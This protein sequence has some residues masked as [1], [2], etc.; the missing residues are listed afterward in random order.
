MA[1]GTF[2]SICTEWPGGDGG[3]DDADGDDEDDQEHENG[4]D[5]RGPGYRPSARTAVSISASSFGISASSS[6]IA[7]CAPPLSTPMFTL[8]TA[9]SSGI[10]GCGPPLECESLL[11]SMSAS[12]VYLFRTAMLIVLIVLIDA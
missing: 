12:S 8:P 7:G 5:L 3:D 2:T 11:V 6:G 4:E 10:A 1:V 9:S